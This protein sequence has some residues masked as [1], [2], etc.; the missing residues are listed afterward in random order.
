MATAGHPSWW[1]QDRKGF[2]GEL[3]VRYFD[4]AAFERHATATQAFRIARVGPLDFARTLAKIAYAYAIARYG[5]DSFEPL[6]LPLILGKSARA[7]YLIGSDGTPTPDQPS[8]LHDLHRLDAHREG[9]APFLG[10]SIRLFAMLGMP[11]YHVILG[12]RLKEGPASEKMG[13]TQA[14]QFPISGW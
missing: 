5:F 14:I 8:V 1:E 9:E 13:D 10:V 12:R 11:R 6:C 2:T 3:V 4:K 7:P